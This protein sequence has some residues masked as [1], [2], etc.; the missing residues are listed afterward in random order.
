MPLISETFKPSQIGA[1]IVYLEFASGGS[2]GGAV[3][4]LCIEELKK[5]AEY[6]EGFYH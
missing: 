6:L 3:I 4:G 2:I 5:G 1:V